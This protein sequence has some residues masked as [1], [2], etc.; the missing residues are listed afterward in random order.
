M[1]ACAEEGCDKKHHA[2][3][4]CSVHFQR[5]N[6]QY[7]KS[8]SVNDL[9][10]AEAQR[11]ATRLKRE[12]KAAMK[13]RHTTMMHNLMSVTGPEE[14]GL[15]VKKVLRLQGR[16]GVVHRRPDMDDAACHGLP[17]EWFYPDDGAVAGYEEAKVICA[18][19]PIKEKCAEWALGAEEHGFW[20]GLSSRA[21]HRI[22][23]H[24]GQMTVDPFGRQWHEALERMAENARRCHETVPTTEPDHEDV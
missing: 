11:E 9:A 2:H 17:T 16:W 23:K 4:L 20:G 1:S 21:R 24:R 19:C 15:E 8:L 12:E 10:R 14:T 6:R 3:G 22:R 5:F 18:S 7:K 13:A